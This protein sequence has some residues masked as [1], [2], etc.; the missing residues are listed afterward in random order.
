MHAQ[1]QVLCPG[2]TTRMHAQ[3]HCAPGE[4]LVCMHKAFVSTQHTWK[5]T[6]CLFQ[7]GTRCSRN[8]TLALN[9]NI[10]LDTT[11]GTIYSPD[12]TSQPTYPPNMTCTWIITAPKDHN[13]K[14]TFSSFE[15]SPANTAC[16]AG[17]FVQ[18]R[19]GKTSDS[20][21]LGSYCSNDTPADI[22]STGQHLWMTFSSDH[23]VERRGFVASYK[24]VREKSIGK[25]SFTKCTAAT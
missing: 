23:S 11:S 24:I 22:F 16:L 19:D 3:G 1:D 13:I 18:L 12:Y 15:L 6:R 4:P 17:D 20:R 2:W 5:L 10:H 7:P 8:N 21:D 25:C 9:N 14:L